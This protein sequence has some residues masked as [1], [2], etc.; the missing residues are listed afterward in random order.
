[1]LLTG[2]DGLLVRVLVDL[3]LEVDVRVVDY[4]VRIKLGRRVPRSGEV[5]REITA[6]LDQIDSI[7]R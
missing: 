2:K 4:N 6:R 7:H 3:R 5:A 1:L